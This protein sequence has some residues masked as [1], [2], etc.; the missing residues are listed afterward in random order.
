[1]QDMEITFYNNLSPIIIV[2]RI[3][4]AF[5]ILAYYIILLFIAL[6]DLNIDL[7]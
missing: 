7:S 5:I 4:L 6:V 1:M 2:K 3:L